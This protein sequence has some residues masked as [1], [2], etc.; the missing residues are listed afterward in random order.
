ALRGELEPTVVVPP[1]PDAPAAP[2]A[3]TE[4]A[5]AVTETLADLYR[6]QGYLADAQSAY[7]A[8]SRA[9]KDDDRRA[10]LESKALHVR[11]APLAT[12]EARLRAWLS[13]FPTK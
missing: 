12:R 7:A 5:P 10:A 13:R 3:P 8:L 1:E 2:P 4:G 6:E 11:E 9:E